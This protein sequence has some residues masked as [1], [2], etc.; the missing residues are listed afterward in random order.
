MPA[1]LTLSIGAQAPAFSLPGVD[2]KTYSLQ[3][4]AG[5]T[6]LVVIFS[7]NHCPTAQALEGRIIA[8]A[9]EFESEGTAFVI[10]NSNEDVH[11]PEDS[12]ENMK[13]RAKEKGYPFPYVRDESQDVARAYG[14]VCT[15]HVFVFDAE[16]KLRY[17]GRVDDNWKDEK[18]VKSRDLRAALDALAKNQEVPNS[19]TLPLGCSVKWRY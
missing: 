12:F 9:K 11:Y 5:K 13:I 1:T 18:A 14:A 10:I 17:S 3:T 2:G 15:P 6:T 8:L 19:E 4:F 16:R 7:C